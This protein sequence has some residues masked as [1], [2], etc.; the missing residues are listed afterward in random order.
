LVA[1]GLC[2]LLAESVL[3]F[4]FRNPAPKRKMYARMIMIAVTTIIKIA[5]STV[6]IAIS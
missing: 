2:W 4:L 3:P 6:M 1:E 5:L